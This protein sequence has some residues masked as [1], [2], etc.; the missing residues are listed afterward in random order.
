MSRALA[1][2]AGV[3]CGALAAGLAF[4]GPSPRKPKR[5]SN[6][7]RSGE[8]VFVVTGRGW[9]HGVGMSQWGAH[10]F[11]RR[12]TS[13]Q[14]ILAHYY[15]GT[16]AAV[17]YE[18]Y[19]DIVGGIGS[20]PVLGNPHYHQATDRLETINQDLVR[21]TARANVAALMLLASSP[22]R[23]T[24]LEP[25]RFANGRAEIRWTP[26]PERSVH[27]YEVA[28]GPA[29]DPFRETITVTEPRAVLA[30][31]APGTTVSVRAINERG[32]HGWD[33]AR[34]ALADR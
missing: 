19:G 8:P 16:D 4:A 30:N 32:L 6:L 1:L 14:R 33:W 24:G 7:P 11:A 3:V 34:L 28:Y 9:G 31:V 18:E 17:F 26:S 2:T 13:Y 20:Y 25:V 23:L 15:R 10:G 21:E 5:V 29:D 22:S 12:G 27:S